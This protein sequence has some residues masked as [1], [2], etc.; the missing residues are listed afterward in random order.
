MKQFFISFFANL[1]ALMF[2]LGGPVLLFVILIIASVSVSDKAKRPTSIER[3]SILVFDMSVNVNDSPEH[4]HGNGSWAGLLGG[5]DDKNVTLRSLTTALRKA[6][7]DDRIRALFLQGSFHP[8]DYGTG[9]ASLRELREAILA[10]EKGDGKTQKKVYAYLEGPTTRDYYVAS[11]ASVIYLNPYGEIEVPGL[12]SVKMYYKGFLDKF[13]IDVQVTRV[14]KYKSAVEPFILTK[15]SEADREETQKLIDDLW[16]N[17]V[18]AVS[19]SR[20]LTPGSFQQ[21][22]D[23]EGYIK[24]EDALEARLVDKLAYFGDVLTELGRIAPA[25]TYAKIPLPFKQIAIA[26]YI[27][28]SHT[29]KLLGEKSSDNE[30]AILYLEG[31]IV[32][33]WGSLDNIGGDRFAAMM[34]QLAA[35]PDVKAVVMRVN[36]PGGSAFASEAIQH[37]MLA[38]KAKKPVVI[39]MGNYAASGGYWISTYGNRIY[40]EPNTLTGSIGVFGLFINVQKLGNDYGFTWDSAKTGTYA[41]FETISRPKSQAELDLAQGR[42]DDLYDKFLKKVS[43][44]RNIQRET[45]EGIAQGRVWSGTEALRLHLV[46]EIGGLDKAIV[47]AADKAKLG[48]GMGDYVVKEY[49]EKINLAQ[50]LAAMFDDHSEPV[51]KAKMDPLTQQFIKIRRELKTFQSLNDPFGVYARMPLG[52]EIR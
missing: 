6:A 44:S 31:E 12:A 43:S 38:L 19:D 27:E 11:A 33:G 9:Y 48:T 35:D 17:V 52:W 24:P 2:V 10:F 32:D 37:E 7:K 3:G 16:G 28:N 34:R 50:V 29:P 13:G 46:D 5:G 15:M 40:A 30:V 4:A 36:S 21:L 42:V 22:V 41:D 20:K 25:S 18:T 1:A 26:D 45:L 14:G 47:Y 39:S 23:K 49:P 8:A 51:I